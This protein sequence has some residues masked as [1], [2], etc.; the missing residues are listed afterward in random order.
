MRQVGQRQE[1]RIAL[2][3]ERLQ[4]SVELLDPLPALAVRVEHAARVLAKSFEPRDF[5]PGCIL[6]ALERLHFHDERAPA[7]IERPQLGEGGVRLEA[8]VLQGCF[9]A[10]RVV[11]QHGGVDH[12]E[13]L[14]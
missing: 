9:D 13:I 2:L 1:H 11:A 10:I 3:L 5:L 7:F 8:A 14:Y 6:R 12:V 4:L